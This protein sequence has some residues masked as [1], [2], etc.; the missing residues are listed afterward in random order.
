MNFKLH[1]HF[2]Y[3]LNTMVLIE[4]HMWKDNIYMVRKHKIDL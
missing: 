1:Q 2:S 3:G 4:D